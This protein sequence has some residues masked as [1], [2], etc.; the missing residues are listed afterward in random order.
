MNAIPSNKLQP[1]I[2]GDIEQMPVGGEWLHI[3][4]QSDEIVLWSSDDI[5]GCTHVFSLPPAWRRWMI[6][7]KPVRVAMPS[8]KAGVLASNDQL[9]RGGNAPQPVVSDGSRLIWL[10]LAVIPMGVVC[11]GCDSTSSSQHHLQWSISSWWSRSG[12]RTRSRQTLS[13][14]VGFFHALVVGSLRRQLRHW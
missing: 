11:S 5:Q 2:K 4:L 7:S 3:A 6:L 14:H 8:D 10:A 13:C 1:A 9:S 12:R